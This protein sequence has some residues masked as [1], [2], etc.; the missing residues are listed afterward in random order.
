MIFV[1]DGPDKEAVPWATQIAEGLIQRLAANTEE[2]QAFRVDT[3]LRPEGKTGTLVRSLHAYRAYYERWAH[4]WEFQALLKARPIAGDQSLGREFTD[5]VR[6]HLFPTEIP[7][8]WLREI[9]GIKAR[10]ERERLGPREDPRTQIK[11]GTG[12]LIRH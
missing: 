1:A 8:E 11:V 12:G 9:R 6:P 3:A 5:L 4:P 2:G 10:I 7:Q